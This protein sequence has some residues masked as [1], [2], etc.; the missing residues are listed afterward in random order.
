MRLVGSRISEPPDSPHGDLVD[1]LAAQTADGW[2][3]FVDR[4][5][6]RGEDHGMADASDRSRVLSEVER[7]QGHFMYLNEELSLSLIHISEPTRPY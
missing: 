4:T 1:G 5:P 3:N 7:L 6:S 2:Q